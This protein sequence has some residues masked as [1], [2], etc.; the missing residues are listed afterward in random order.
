MVWT[1]LILL[2]V[3]GWTAFVIRQQWRRRRTSNAC[4]NCALRDAC[5]SK[6]REKENGQPAGCPSSERADDGCPKE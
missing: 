3:G 5:D 2:A 4:D 1:I 6:R